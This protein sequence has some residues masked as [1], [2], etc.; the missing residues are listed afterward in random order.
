MHQLLKRNVLHLTLLPKALF[1]NMEMESTN[2]SSLA[3][4]L[5]EVTG[6]VATKSFSIALERPT[7][8]DAGIV[9]SEAFPFMLRLRRC[10]L[11]SFLYGIQKNSQS[12][13]NEVD[14]IVTMWNLVVVSAFSPTEPSLSVNTGVPGKTGIWRLRATENDE[15]TEQ[16]N[17]KQASFW[18]NYTF[19]FFQ[20]PCYA[21]GEVGKM[22]KF[23]DGREFC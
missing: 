2:Y 4:C 18:L 5:L 23:N 16:K 21:V 8:L 10:L 15:G 17:W 9:C 3:S 12:L 13:G 19:Y 22:K 1:R 11:T 20:I 6:L 14:R 7:W